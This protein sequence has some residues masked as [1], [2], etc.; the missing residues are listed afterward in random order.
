[1]GLIG[2]FEHKL[3]A[4]GRVVIP[5]NFREELGSRIVATTID[6]TCISLYSER[7]WEEVVLR[8]NELSRQS[9][10]GEKI[11]RRILANSFKQEMDAMGRM[12]IPETLRLAVNINIS[13]DVSVNG[14]NKKAE[15]WDLER[16]RQYMTDSNEL[17]PDIK[18][19]IPGL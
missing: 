16:W 8:L 11:Q 6:N 15:I 19:L 1:M 5:V 18:T 2:N 12:L 10:N 3:D 14:I 17:I 7:N 13:Q 9:P 4:K